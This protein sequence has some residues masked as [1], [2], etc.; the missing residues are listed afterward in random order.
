MNPL[1]GLFQ[2][3]PQ[4][5]TPGT[6]LMFPSALSPNMGRDADVPGRQPGQP[7]PT[8]QV[9]WKD[10]FAPIDT[11]SKTTTVNPLKGLFQQQPQYP[12]PGTTHMFPEAT[13]KHLGED[14]ATPGRQ[15]GTATPV[16]QT[17][18]KDPS[19]PPE[20]P[21]KDNTNYLKGLFQQQPQYPTP[22]TT[23][24]FPEAVQHNLGT[25]SATPGKD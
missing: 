5:P 16:Y 21:S 14:S 25:D 7:A 20:Q 9:P 3:Q 13:P 17:E 11:T 4:Y 6:T 1:E 24:A 8:Y 2:Q 19:A 23:L 10:P 12:T 18:W 15:P 22:G